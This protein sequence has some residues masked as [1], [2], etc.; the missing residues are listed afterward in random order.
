MTKPEAFNAIAKNL[1]LTATVIA[2]LLDHKKYWEVSLQNAALRH[3]NEQIVKS[4]E[5]LM[6]AKEALKLLGFSGELQ[7]IQHLKLIENENV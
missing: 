6:Q 3:D 4:K 5:N 2:A 7:N 1:F